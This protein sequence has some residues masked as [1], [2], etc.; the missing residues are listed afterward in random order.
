MKTTVW[1]PFRGCHKISSGCKNCYIALGDSKKGKDFD[2][3]EKTSM[4]D[5]PIKKNK[6]G[7]YVIP[8]GTL[9]YTSFS[10]DF[11]LEDIDS[12]R[13]ELWKMISIRKDLKFMFLTKRI[14]RFN[15]VIPSDWEDGY[16]HVSVGVS[17]ENQ[18]TADERLPYL[19]KAKMKHKMIICQPLIDRIDLSNYLS[20]IELVTVGGEAA[21]EGRVL[22]DMWV[23]EIKDTCIK[24]HVSFSFRQAASNYL[25]DGEI[26]HLR[27]HELSKVARDQMRDVSF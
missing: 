13:E 7:E 24:H 10:S 26:K 22:D 18:M 20:G 11:L 4:Y 2:L 25:K 1:N 19:L 12:Y 14:A 3:I 5:R 15:D 9:V 16:E 8:S 23:E 17:V 6:K 27:W 21:K